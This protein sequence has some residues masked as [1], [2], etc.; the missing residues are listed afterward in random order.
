MAHFAKLDDNNTVIH[1]SF[2]NNENIIDEN[3]QESESLGIEYLKSIHGENTKW[4][5]TSYNSN[6]KKMYA[7]IGYTYNEQYDVFLPPK[8]FP[9]WVLNTESFEWESPIRRP[10][11]EGV[12]YYWNE[13]EKIW[14]E[15]NNYPLIMVN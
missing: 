9:S 13:N 4:K 5:Q 12:V 11:K 14:V 2:V 15:D 6:L 8:L 7:G 10:Y 3:G 1:V